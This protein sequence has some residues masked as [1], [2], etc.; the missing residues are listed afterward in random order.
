[1]KGIEFDIDNK[2]T[3]LEDNKQKKCVVLG[4]KYQE[5]THWGSEL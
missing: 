2:R 3:Y 1:L 4:D 5:V